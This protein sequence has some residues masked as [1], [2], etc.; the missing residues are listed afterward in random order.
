MIVLNDHLPIQLHREGES[1]EEAYVDICAGEQCITELPAIGRLLK[2]LELL[3]YYNV[4]FAG[5]VE[6]FDQGL[7]A[8]DG[9]RCRHDRMIVVGGEVILEVGKQKRLF[10]K[11]SVKME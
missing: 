5:R 7:D 2:V 11:Q 10:V 1:S 3:L 8:R 6:A 9:L 4:L